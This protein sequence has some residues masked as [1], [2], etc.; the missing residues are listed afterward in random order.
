VNSEEPRTP[1]A[2]TNITVREFFAQYD[3]A[4]RDTMKRRSLE[5]YRDIARLH[6]LLA[7]GNIPRRWVNKPPGSV[8]RGKIH[9]RFIVPC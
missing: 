3:D 9:R 6:L 4:V 5:T 7:F 8:P 1:F 2:A